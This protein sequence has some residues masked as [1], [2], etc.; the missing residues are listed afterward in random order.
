MRAFLSLYLSNLFLVGGSG[1]LTTYLAVVLAR[2]EVSTGLIGLL[3]S[4][5]YLGLLIGAKIGYILIKNVGHIRTFAASTAIVTTCVAFHGLFDNVYFWLVLRLIVGI[6]MMCNYMVL[7]SWL[8]EQASPEHRGRIFSVYM[9][10]SYLGMMLGQASL[11]YYP[12]LG[13]EPLLLICIA[14]T[15]GIVPLN[16]SRRIHPKPLKPITVSFFYFVK[17]APQALVAVFFAGII[18][19]SFYGLAPVFTQLAGFSGEQVA[20]YMFVTVLAGFL[21]QWPMGVLSDKVARSRLLRANAIFISVIAAA[22]YLLSQNDIYSFVLTFA[23]GLFIFT[24]YPLCAALANSRVDDEDRVGV[25]SA[26]LVAFGV[27]ASFGSGAI[28]K[29]MDVFGYA[30]LYGSIALLAIVMFLL[31]TVIN[32]KQKREKP[33]DNDYMVA[34]SD[35]NASPMVSALDPRIEEDVAQEQLMVTEE[36]ELATELDLEEQELE[37]QKR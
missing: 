29:I 15:I 35:V 22:I 6:A 5:N 14:L 19:G 20:L 10:T 9:I 16:I 18:S 4:M 1:L 36:E 34:A 2:A 25:A 21:A 17:K 7:E 3:S 28:A 37:G 33:S 27:G 11:S 24:L 23:Y 8:N 32:A 30:A 12:E 26:L 31:L 13:L